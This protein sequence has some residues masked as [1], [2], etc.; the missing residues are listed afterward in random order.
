MADLARWLTAEL[1]AFRKRMFQWDVLNENPEAIAKLKADI[2]MNIEHEHQ[3]VGGSDADAILLEELRVDVAEQLDVAERAETLVEATSLEGNPFPDVEVRAA[4][5][6][7]GEEGEACSMEAKDTEGEECY[8]LPGEEEERLVAT[9]GCPPWWSRLARCGI[10]GCRVFRKRAEPFRA[11]A[12]E[13]FWETA[14]A[15]FRAEVLVK[16]L[17]SFERMPLETVEACALV[18]QHFC[19]LCSWRPRDV[20]H[21]AAPPAELFQSYSPSDFIQQYFLLRHKVIPKL[22][23]SPEGMAVWKVKAFRIKLDSGREVVVEADQVSEDTEGAGTIWGPN[24]SLQMGTA[25]C[26]GTKVI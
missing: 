21:W 26:I 10:G 19:I 17:E 7:G 1:L 5:A 9:A 6:A 18:F 11:C 2:S 24:T 4:P 20:S 13:K 15:A 23:G 8:G 22:L 3:A 14:S 12:I 25:S 16:P